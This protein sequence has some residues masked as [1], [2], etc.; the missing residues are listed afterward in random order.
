L[1]AISETL[2]P[3][4]EDAQVRFAIA[5]S[6]QE[7]NDAMAVAPSPDLSSSSPA[8]YAASSTSTSTNVTS[9]ATSDTSITTNTVVSAVETPEE[10]RKKIDASLLKRGL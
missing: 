8:Y 10:R 5:A 4:D 9:T 3:F 6:L 7:L 2:L 1:P